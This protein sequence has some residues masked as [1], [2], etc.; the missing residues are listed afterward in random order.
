MWIGEIPGETKS[1][2]ATC[3]ILP[4]I[5]PKRENEE[6]VSL[7]KVLPLRDDKNAPRGKCIA[8]Y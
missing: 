2:K 5:K 6:N 7:Y 3:R 1:W 4:R 8:L